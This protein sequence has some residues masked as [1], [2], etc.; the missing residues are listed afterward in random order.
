MLVR[1]RASDATLTNL[2]GRPLPAVRYVNCLTFD[3][4]QHTRHRPILGNNYVTARHPSSM[5]AIERLPRRF[6]VPGR[7]T[8]TFKTAERLR[9]RPTRS[10]ICGFATP[11]KGAE[12]VENVTVYSY[13]AYP[14]PPNAILLESVHTLFRITNDQLLES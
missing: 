10:L 12:T 4:G 1:V 14:L 9:N 13:H 8:V 6:M 5:P 3:L 11:L 2:D 7:R